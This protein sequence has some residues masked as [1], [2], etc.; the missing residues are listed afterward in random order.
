MYGI[1]FIDSY[2]TI[3]M[4]AFLDG[5]GNYFCTNFSMESTG[6]H[7]YSRHESD[8]VFNMKNILEALAFLNVET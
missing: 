5:N 6:T 2:A 7:Y 4:K 1:Y 3:K 8:V